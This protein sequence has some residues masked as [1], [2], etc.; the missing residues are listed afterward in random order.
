MDG[1]VPGLSSVVALD[2]PHSETDTFCWVSPATPD[3]M[4][5]AGQEI[6]VSFRLFASGTCP[7]NP[8]MPIR[9][10]MARLS[11]SRVD[12]TTGETVFPPLREK[13]EGNKFHWDHENGLNEFDL[14]TEGLAPGTYTITVFGSKFS[15]T[16][17]DIMLNG[18]PGCLVIF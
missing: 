6:E 9:D 13:E 7:G 18:N 14:S 15:P 2:E 10:K 16:S 1:L 4:Y 8:G 3:Q 17:R 5:T 11:L 12:P